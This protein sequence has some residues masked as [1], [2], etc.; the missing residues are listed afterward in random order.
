MLPPSLTAKISLK[1]GVPSLAHSHFITVDAASGAILKSRREHTVV[2]ISRRLDYDAVQKFHDT[3]KAPDE[4]SQA[5]MPAGITGG[6]PAGG[7]AG[8][9]S[10]AGLR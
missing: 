9:C 6:C 1:A 3:G 8:D 10:L 2:T 5:G 7:H 4:W